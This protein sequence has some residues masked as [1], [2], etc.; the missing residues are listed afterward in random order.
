[1]IFIIIII[2]IIIIDLFFDIISI[3][4]LIAQI[5]VDNGIKSPSLTQEAARGHA[6]LHMNLVSKPESL[7]RI[8]KWYRCRLSVAGP[9]APTSSPSGPW[10][11]NKN[12]NV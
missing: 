8:V 2:I 4:I 12:K 9:K 11:T 5:L 7:H 10:A 6:H 1:M 3:L